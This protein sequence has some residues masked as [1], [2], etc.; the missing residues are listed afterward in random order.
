MEV[1]NL[2]KQIHY[3]SNK[4]KLLIIISSNKIYL[5]VKEPCEGK[6]PLLINKREGRGSK[7]LS[8]SKAFIEYPHHMDDIYKNIVE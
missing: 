8:D 2:E 7:H 1:L 4:F 3:L 6:C 5:Y